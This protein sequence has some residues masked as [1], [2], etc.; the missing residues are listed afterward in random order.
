MFKH[1][2][3]NGSNCCMYYIIL[4]IFKYSILSIQYCRSSG[5]R[6]P[7]LSGLSKA[8]KSESSKSFWAQWLIKIIFLRFS[9]T[10]THRMTWSGLCKI[11]SNVNWL[12]LLKEALPGHPTKSKFPNTINFRWAIRQ[13]SN[14]TQDDGDTCVLWNLQNQ[15]LRNS[16]KYM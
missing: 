12:R 8:C 13:T 4:Y 15:K 6:G 5:S 3:P 7:T 9:Q 11:P 14:F 1:M 2:Q 16:I 10:S